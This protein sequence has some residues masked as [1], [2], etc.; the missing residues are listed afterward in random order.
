MPFDSTN[1][2]VQWS[3]KRPFDSVSAVLDLLGPV[4]GLHV[5]V[6]GPGSLDPMLALHRRGAASVTAVRDGARIRAE[7]ADAAIA[8]R[9]GTPELADA[10][11]LLARRAIRPL[12]TLVLV[13]TADA[14]STLLAHVRRRLAESGFGFGRIVPVGNA[15]AV[16]ADL[17]LYGR[18]AH[19]AQSSRAA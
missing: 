4:D 1:S 3:R 16:Q 9:I 18:L 17:P 5:L 14:P 15:Y 7:A 2:V 10:A 11:I 8:P 13:L 6:I 19:H 12:N